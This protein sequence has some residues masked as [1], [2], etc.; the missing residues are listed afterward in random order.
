MAPAV[1]TLSLKKRHR[2][3][4]DHQKYTNGETRFVQLGSVHTRPQWG[5]HSISKV[6]MRPKRSFPH[7]LQGHVKQP[8]NHQQAAF[9]T[10]L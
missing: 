10:V 8:T 7:N 5:S 3:R 2:R 6:H 9:V 1:A 4:Y